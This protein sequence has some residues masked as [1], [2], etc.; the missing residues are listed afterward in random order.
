MGLSR[1]Y[2]E[3]D[4]GLEESYIL[5]KNLTHY[6]RN[7]L[8]VKAGS[9]VVLFNGQG[10][11]FLAQID[12]IEKRETRIST[13]AFEPTNRESTLII[14]LGISVVKRDAMDNIIL[15]STEMGVSEIQPLIAD[16]TT[17]STKTIRQRGEHWR[18][19]TISACEQCGRNKLP[20]LLTPISTH[21]W[22]SSTT[23]QLK[24]A[25]DPGGSHSLIEHYSDTEESGPK[26]V[27]VLIGPEGGLSQDE[28]ALA[29]SSG[30]LMTS[31]GQRIL[32][33]DTAPVATLSI[34]QAR[35]G[36]FSAPSN[37]TLQTSDST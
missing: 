17:V 19:I 37:A 7:V 6:L 2:I 32:R 3:Q 12:A 20:A 26:D 4:L 27:A 5:D 28:L 22:I 33:A 13:L 15:K 21:D 31:L 34:L 24:L 35:F 23:S 8:R 1:F 18:A 16:L 10:G 14:R 11:E 25:M 29:Q 9:Q 36:D 30:F